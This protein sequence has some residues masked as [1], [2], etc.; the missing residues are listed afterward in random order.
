MFRDEGV[1]MVAR[2]VR[3]SFA[4]IAFSLLLVLTVCAAGSGTIT[5]LTASDAPDHGD[6]VRVRSSERAD[7]KINSSNL[8]YTIIAPDG[9]TVV[10][11]HSTTM[12]SMKAGDTY[13]D[14][15]STSNSSFPGVGTYTVNLCWSNGGSQNCGI[16][17]ASTTFYSVPS[18][19][20]FLSLVAL[21]LIAIWVWRRRHEFA[22]ELA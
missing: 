22:S 15:W 13:N 7:G 9:V 14:S 3:I 5:S 10:A 18:L 16:D 20:W 11:T 8:Y 21:V 6:S 2:S 12:P 4:A 1:G 17:S 19:G